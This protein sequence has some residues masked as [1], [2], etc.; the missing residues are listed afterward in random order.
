MSHLNAHII[1]ACPPAQAGSRLKAFLRDRGNR[2]GGIA[3]FALSIDVEV[4]GLPIPL[5][6]QRSIIATIQPHHAAGDMEPRYSVQWAPEHPGQFPLFAGEFIIEGTGD[7]QSFIIRIVGAYTPP[8]GVFGKGFDA[9]IGNRIA[10]TVANDLLRRM[11]DT[12][13]HDY[14]ADEEQ[15]RPAT[16]GPKET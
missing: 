4:P 6:L 3:K 10:Q 8:L 11:R 13:E 15:K 9:A 7:Y 1:V 12:I 16:Q 14:R 2:D 5:K